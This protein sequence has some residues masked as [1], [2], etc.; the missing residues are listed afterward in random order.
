LVAKSRFLGKKVLETC[1]SHHGINKPKRKQGMANDK[2]SLALRISISRPVLEFL[3]DENPGNSENCRLKNFRLS[4][5]LRTNQLPAGS[6]STGIITTIPREYDFL[7]P[8]RFGGAA[9]L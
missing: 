7:Y 3:L 9:S 4:A 6:L 8:R 5:E 2:P 1:I